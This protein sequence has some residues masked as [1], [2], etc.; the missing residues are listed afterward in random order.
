MSTVDA[1]EL[2]GPPAPPWFGTPSIRHLLQRTKRLLAR[3]TVAHD[4]LAS[5]SLGS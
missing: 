1:H 5:T 2:C 3:F 4:P